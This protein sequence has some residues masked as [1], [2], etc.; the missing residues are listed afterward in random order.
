M[1]QRERAAFHEAGHAVV[2]RYFGMGIKKITI[3]EDDESYGRVS[4]RPPGDWFR[5]D[6]EIDGRR[7]RRIELE[8]MTGWAGTLAEE[9]HA[10]ESE[11]TIAGAR[12]DINQ[13]ANLALY[14]SGS[15][16]EAEAYIEW[17]RLRTLGI[18]RV[19]WGEIEAVAT[20]LLERET[21][22]GKQWGLST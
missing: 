17:L 8:I 2:R 15:E 16:E 14:A 20:A 18:L 5:P 1:N 19:M 9:M 11:A 6:I 21:L 22:T 13:I 4:N 10:G 12:E 7:R 3:V